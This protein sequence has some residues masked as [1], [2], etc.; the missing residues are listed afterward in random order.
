M[1]D[2]WDALHKTHLCC[3]AALQG[4]GVVIAC[5]ARQ[6]GLAGLRQASRAR[7][8]MSKQATSA[9]YLQHVLRMERVDP[10]P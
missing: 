1:Q 9:A 7:L 2:A 8:G 5:A 10:D 3:P 6:G 4:Q